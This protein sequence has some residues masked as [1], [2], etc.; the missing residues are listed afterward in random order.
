MRLDHVINRAMGMDSDEWQRHANP[1][2]VWTRLATI[3]AF[4]LAVYARMWLGW[5][6]LLPVIVIIVFLWLNTRIFAPAQTD[7]RWETRAI[8][9]ERIW[10]DRDVTA[11]RDDHLRAVRWIATG[12]SLCSV[13]LII[14]LVWLDPWATAFGA[15]GMFFG[16]AW[17]LDRFAWLYETKRSC[18]SDVGRHG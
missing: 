15:A 3:P 17:L 4:A 6:S 14:G 10:L 18:S 9:G 11:I 8:L 7:E 5:W 1:W 16:Q 12:S 2:S 13:P